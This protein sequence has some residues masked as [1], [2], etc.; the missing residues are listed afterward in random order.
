MRLNFGAG[1]N[2]HVVDLVYLIEIHEQS[3]PV[4]R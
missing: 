3:N 2:Q 1:D 4:H